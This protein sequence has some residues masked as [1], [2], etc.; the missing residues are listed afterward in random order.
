MLRPPPALAVAETTELPLAS[1]GAL[2]TATLA[3]SGDGIAYAARLLRT[4]IAD[5]IGH[6]PTVVELGVT[7]AQPVALKTRVQF[8]ARLARLQ[9]LRR[10]DWLL[11]TH[12]GIARAQ[13]R[14][15]K[16]WRRPYGVMLHGIE[17]WS[18]TLDAERKAALREARVR[19]AISPHTARRVAMAHPGLPPVDTCLL[20]LLPD[21]EHPDRVPADVRV[22]FG[23]H[24]VVI[25][26]RM[27]AAERYKGHDQLLLA[28]PRVLADLPDATLVMVG[29]GDDVDRLRAKAAAL[30]LGRS[31]QFTG[32]VPDPALRALLRHSAVFAM[33]SRGEGFGLVYLQAM[34]AG[35]P[36]LGSRDDAAADI[37][38]DGETGLL[39]PHQD[40]DAIAGALVRLLTDD[41]MRRRMG[42]AG[43]RRF[44]ATFTYPRFRSRLAALLGR[45]FPAPTKDR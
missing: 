6:D 40:P 14:V 35:V 44:E 34:R 27:S 16:Q 2:A 31:V 11:F 12:V 38:V 21:D 28:W 1:R 36:C 39:V 30:G 26:G 17:A 23:P 3:P 24:A 37:I 45:A 25:V 29:R 7:E 8:L 9:S 13:L 42:E 33:P 10:V 41:G 43:R 19:I 18:A 32:F 5:L 4:A 22:D 15:P 20:A